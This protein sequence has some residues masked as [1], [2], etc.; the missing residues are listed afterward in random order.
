MLCQAAFDQWLTTIMQHLS[1]LSK[2]QAT[3][4]ALWSFGMVLARSCA[5]S[6]VS[7]L[8]AAGRQRNAQP[9]RQ[10]RRAGY[11]DAPRNRGTTRQERR[12]ETCLPLLLGWVVRWWH[13]TPRALAIE[14][15]PWGQR[16]VGLALRVV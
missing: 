7:N 5:L 9:V 11:Y 14:A 4:L 2:P 1:P 13:G 6:A 12:V 8:L 3:V 16:W 15:T 10:R